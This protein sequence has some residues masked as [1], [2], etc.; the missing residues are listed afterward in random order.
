MF[1]YYNDSG[2]Y[3]F[4]ANEGGEAEDLTVNPFK[5][6]AQRRWMYA[7]DPAMAARW[8]AVTPKDEDLPEYVE[9][10]EAAKKKRRK[11]G[12][13]PVGNASKLRSKKVRQAKLKQSS[14]SNPARMDPAGLSPL[15]NA[16]NLWLSR[17]YDAFKTEVVK[18][19][20][21]GAALST[22][23][24][25]VFCP[26]GKGGGVDPGCSPEG[27]VRGPDGNPLTVYRGVARG[28]TEELGESQQGMYGKGY[29]FTQD[30][31]VA[32][33]YAA[34]IGAPEQQKKVPVEQIKEY[35]L[36][37]LKESQ[38]V[39]GGYATPGDNYRNVLDWVGSMKE[40][41]RLNDIAL[42]MVK[43]EAPTFDLSP[44]LHPS[45]QKR[46]IK[47]VHLTSHKML[48]LA[49]EV[50]KGDVSDQFEKS[51]TKATRASKQLS[52]Q[53]K[54]EIVKAVK[55]NSVYGGAYRKN[56]YAKVA[57]VTGVDRANDL[58]RS[59]G[60]DAIKVWG[61][62]GG[63]AHM[64]YVVFH[65]S[66]VK[67]VGSEDA[68]PKK[69]LTNRLYGEDLGNGVEYLDVAV[70]V[71]NFN[72]H[73]D[74]QGRFSSSSAT[75][76]PGRSSGEGASSS[77][78]DALKSLGVK[79]GHLHHMVEAYAS[80]KIAN[81]VGKLPKAAQSVVKTGWAG[82]FA[83]Y[84]AAQHMT[85]RIA[86]ER[87]LSD[88]EARRLRGTLSSFDMG[89][90]TAF[91]TA[92]IAGV[93]AAHLPTVVTGLIPVASASYLAYSTARH[94]IA[95]L[96]AACGVVKDVVTSRAAKAIGRAV[97][98]GYRA[99][100]KGVDLLAGNVSTAEANATLV[101]WHLRNHGYSD[102]YIALLS[103]AMSVT[104]NVRAALDLADHAW[105]VHSGDT[106]KP[107]NEG[108]EEWLLHTLPDELG[109]GVHNFN[110]HHDERGRF[111]SA[112]EGGEAEKGQP[113]IRKVS[114][115][116][117]R[118]AD[119]T[120]EERDRWGY[121]GPM[122]LAP[123][124]ESG[125]LFER[126]GRQWR[127]AGKCNLDSGRVTL[128][129]KGIHSKE[130]AITITN[131]EMMHGTFEKVCQ[132]YNVQKDKIR[133][134]EDKRIDEW[135][136][137]HPGAT[138][139]ERARVIDDR[140]A[141]T[142][143]SGEIKEEY[144]KQY[145]VYARMWRFRDSIPYDDFA[146][147]DGVTDYSKAYWKDYAAG[148]CTFHIAV[149]ET[150][151]EIAGHHAVTGVIIG[152]KLFRDYYKTVRDEYRVHTE[153][154]SRRR[155][156]HGED[157][158][159][160][161]QAPLFVDHDLYLDA[162]FKPTTPGKASWLRWWKA[163]GT[164]GWAVP[165]DQVHNVLNFNPYHD[166]KGRFSSS[167]E[168]GGGVGTT[169]S[170]AR[171]PQTETPAFKRWFGDSKVVD[172]NGK[173]R[174]CFHGSGTHFE[175]FKTGDNPDPYA[176]LDEMLGSHFAEDPTLSD[177]FLKERGE[178]GEDRYKTGAVLY[179]VYLSIQKPRVAPQRIMPSGELEHDAYAINRDILDTVMPHEKELFVK[180]IAKSR[181]VTPE[182]GREIF[183]R[184][185]RGESIGKDE[186]N[187]VVGHDMTSSY[188]IPGQPGVA[189]YLSNY[190][191]S[192]LGMS[193]EDKQYVVSEYKRRLGEMGYDGIVY[194]DT[195]PMEKGE[196]SQK[197]WIAFNPGQIKSATGNRGTF[198]PGDPN[199]H[200]VWSEEAHEAA[201]EARRAHM[202]GPAE[203]PSSA[204]NPSSTS[205]PGNVSGQDR[206]KGVTSRWASTLSVFG[207]VLYHAA[208]AIAEAV[209]DTAEDMGK[210]TFA[211]HAGLLR[212]HFGIGSNVS[213]VL[214]SHA[215]AFG[216]RKARDYIQ[217]RRAGK[218]VPATNAQGA[219]LGGMIPTDHPDFEQGVK[220]L[221]SL[222][223]TICGSLGIPAPTEQEVAKHMA[224]PRPETVDAGS[225]SVPQGRADVLGK[226]AMLTPF[227]PAA[228]ATGNP[229]PAVK[230]TGNYDFVQAVTAIAREA[231]DRKDSP[232]YGQLFWKP[233]M[234]E[235][236]YVTADGDE[237]EFARWVE[238]ELAKHVGN[239]VRVEAEG[240]PPRDGSWEILYPKRK[241]WGKP[242]DNE[243]QHFVHNGST[244]W[245][246]V[247]NGLK[248]LNA[249]DVRQINHFSCGDGAAMTVAW[250]FGVGPGADLWQRYRDRWQDKGVQD[251]VRK[252][253]KVWQDNLGTTEEE[254]TR[255]Q[256]IVD[257]L[258]RLG[259]YVEDS[260]GLTVQDLAG[261]IA[262]GMPI[263]VCCQ[264]YGPAVPAKARFD[265]GHYMV[266]IGVDGGYI[267]LQDPSEDNVVAGGDKEALSKTGSIQQPGRIMVAED[268]WNRI[269]I[270]RD[271]DGNVYDH[272]GIAVGRSPITNQPQ[273]VWLPIEDIL[274]QDETATP[275][276][277]ITDPD[278]VPPVLVGS[279]GYLIDGRHRI[280]GLKLGGQTHCWAIVS[281]SYGL[282][283]SQEGLSGVG[284][285]ND[286]TVNA[287]S[288][289]A[290]AAS[291][292][293]RQATRVAHEATERAWR[294][295]APA[296]RA[297]RN[298]PLGS[299]RVSRA[300]V[301]A[302]R[303]LPRRGM[304]SNRQRAIALHGAAATHHDLA[305][306]QH[307]QGSQLALDE[308]D[309][310]LAQMHSDAAAAHNR[311]VTAHLRA[312]TALG[313]QGHHLGTENFNPY[314]GERG[315]FTSAMEAISGTGTRED[316]YRCKGNIELA[317][318]LLAAGHHIR[319]EQ[320]E[321]VSTLLKEMHDMV[322]HYVK[323][324]EAPPQFDLCRVSIKGTNLFC[325]QHKGIPRV[326][327]PQMTGIPAPGTPAADESKYPRN[328][329]GK[330]S[331]A[332]DF[333]DHLQ[334]QGIKVT[335]EDIPA[336]HLRA[337]QREIS[338]RQV[339]LL[340]DEAKRGVRD[341]RKKPIW[342]SKEGYVIDGHHHWAAIVGYGYGKDKDLKVPVYR[343]DAEIG[344][345]LD[346]A[347][348]FAAH[349]G[350]R[351]EAVAN[352]NPYHDEMGR[353]SSG[354]VTHRFVTKGGGVYYHHDDGTTTRY[355]KGV[356]DAVRVVMERLEGLKGKKL[357]AEWRRRN[358][359]IQ[360][361]SS[362][363]F[364]IPAAEMKRLE[365]LGPG[366]RVSVKKGRL[367]VGSQP[368]RTLDSPKKGATPY[369]MWDEG[370]GP[371]G[372]SG[373]HRG[374]PITRVQRVK[375]PSSPAGNFNPHHGEHGRFA[376]AD[377]ALSHVKSMIA[378]SPHS[379][380]VGQV[381]DRMS[382]TAHERLGKH[383][384]SVRWHPTQGHLTA[385]L[386]QEDPK[387]KAYIEDSRTPDG[388]I[389]RIIK[390]AYDPRTGQLDLDG[391]GMH[392]GKSVQAHDYAAHELGHAVDGPQHELSNHPDFKQAWETEGKAGMVGDRG[393]V[394]PAEY[395]AE[396]WRLLHSEDFKGAR[397]RNVEANMPKT[398][399]FIRA[400]GL[401]PVTANRHLVAHSSQDFVPLQEEIPWGEGDEGKPLQDD[402]FGESFT[403][404][405]GLHIDVGPAE[406]GVSTSTA[407]DRATRG[408]T[409][410]H[411]AL[412]SPSSA[413]SSNAD[414]DRVSRFNAWLSRL[415]QQYL[416]G[417]KQRKAWYDFILNGYVKGSGR[418]YDDS[419]R[420]EQSYASTQDA[421]E[422]SNGTLGQ[423]TGNAGFYSAREMGKR[424]QFL[425]D[426]LSKQ[427]VKDRIQT[428]CDRAFDEFEGGTAD[429]VRRMKRSF[430]DALQ[431]NRSPEWLARR[432]ASDAGMGLN[433]ARTTARTELT[434]AHASAQ[435]Q[436]YR[437]LG[438]RE[439]GL[440]A[441]WKTAANPC[442]KCEPL[443]GV[444][445]DVDQ[446][447]G[448]IPRH[449]G[450]L[451][452]WQ[453]AS[454]NERRKD[455]IATPGAI[456][457]AFEESTDE[458]D[459]D[460]PGQEMI[461]NEAA[462]IDP[463][464]PDVPLDVALNAFDGFDG[465]DEVLGRNAWCPTGKGGGKDDSCSPSRGGGGGPERSGR[466]LGSLKRRAEQRRMARRVA[467]RMA[468][469]A[470]EEAAGV[471]KV[472]KPEEDRANEI[473]QEVAKM[474][475][476][477]W[478][479]D[480]EEMDVD[481]VKDMPGHV[482][483][484]K[485]LLFTT[486]QGSK[487]VPTIH[488]DALYRKAMWSKQTGDQYHLVVV[489]DRDTWEGGK[490][491]QYY[492][493]HRM[494][495]QRGCKDSTIS[496]MIPVRNAAH[497]RRLM[498]M[499]ESELPAT[500]VRPLPSSDEDLEDL[501]VKAVKAKESRVAK[502]RTYRQEMR[503][504]G[505]DVNVSLLG[506]VPK[507][508]KGKKRRR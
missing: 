501:R 410:D 219:F 209:L 23:I 103:A 304:D 432:L 346:R 127:E 393:K 245:H 91:K 272:Y 57:A 41:G 134:E 239:R 160:Q 243:Y 2:P 220:L 421:I 223:Q 177:S 343:L 55:L 263:I 229:S 327:M 274:G 405:D 73:H 181:G 153:Q 452:S 290:R 313:G 210:I 418:A 298:A 259:L 281:D 144:R 113:E 351:R 94:P 339:S 207:K 42:E 367:H 321:Q 106:S 105:T 148:K 238:G 254:S 389:H 154:Q 192:L 424:A 123:E 65:P 292:A 166:D 86:R 297:G 396:V 119:V 218:T 16:F 341:L 79:A 337:S 317:A 294:A 448:L 140:L 221:S 271:I 322:Q 99:A 269:W 377:E 467:K 289:A 69:F 264:D 40:G 25:N 326:K 171:V 378:G 169:P 228:A 162:D 11:K 244:V 450:C 459:D 359:E 412:G 420:A 379:E 288:D 451:C 487:A 363:T 15:C 260:H 135:N 224:H 503:A 319:L 354:D 83:V 390:G 445:L 78:V 426:H 429:T 483:E 258:R 206:L 331:I 498:R 89:T 329:K 308:G 496:Q 194:T 291:L 6:A 270:D 26:T 60:Y 384:S 306:Q 398:M 495:Y 156:Q 104:P 197:A 232:D 299:Y 213:L 433:R 214:A 470:A 33:V 256:A 155:K 401:M 458:G 36:K 39:K 303:E 328:K 408:V 324:D 174:V 109:D 478:L 59:M 372:Q 296:M 72:P 314:H 473:E 365:K 17:Q 447:E 251:Q 455:Q 499:D 138:L 472:A 143:P 247:G 226:A 22:I 44:V 323:G 47:H 236:W 315:R 204:A 188:R 423:P 282:A 145:P 184:L 355:S 348:E 217:A 449:P 7:N 461:G 64:M 338:G 279:D 45:I 85:E 285:P 387:I 307:I 362:R 161:A 383:L 182:Q 49:E 179:P 425:K 183:D 395:F 215:L 1:P 196:K 277:A 132:L 268:D 61:R 112:G 240:F 205:P 300:A 63:R 417:P 388:K 46:E 172:E 165:A 234:G 178:W 43:R 477:H 444:V 107:D 125:K 54:R 334:S 19:A 422:A 62:T 439:V 493:G 102:W 504:I 201:L 440:R 332:R 180:W 151:A 435:L 276:S 20:G 431:G 248:I 353:F 368:V 12:K 454:A 149:H 202:K 233:D 30:K 82:L 242:T 309:A 10:S 187:K 488:P 287:W 370:A 414:S 283:P 489:D 399:G 347:N 170:A 382:S 457:D 375:P 157:V 480:D 305:E 249:P 443:D 158:T 266:V 100:V 284:E 150:L 293:A 98:G 404:P 136:R 505:F 9:G 301:L 336:S 330:V 325:E 96:R 80:D 175:E 203:Q 366:A 340:V 159:N 124:T 246:P 139:G 133:E 168:G 485:S 482:V 195:A 167:D 231:K 198:D 76:S 416:T 373:Y 56:I 402:V 101:D 18:T 311:A 13:R 75:S 312:V 302:S 128:F 90:F 29:Y 407:G 35:I 211:K 491:K 265:Y 152:S 413:L 67:Q 31:N 411:G 14:R 295:Q 114:A 216:I 212:H 34:H 502:D 261:Y 117:A 419:T 486:Q 434:R 173:P 200:N 320:P 115:W 164:N 37:N 380:T 110:P 342:I 475:R 92:T 273:K 506:Q 456:R 374:H 5:S 8:E 437:D 84:R 349:M 108:D 350:L 193:R 252:V 464:D 147:D 185:S 468:K 51:V 465:R 364:Y 253:F 462:G 116:Y 189:S 262:R 333:I 68:D 507:P 463:F 403:A 48:D 74:E 38:C 28:G 361:R 391:P 137:A 428:L 97:A 163:D 381:L 77:I 50:S 335:R 250:L 141:M 95:T 446:A 24:G 386:M 227:Q 385:R 32:N 53:E 460:W 427:D 409:E 438:H 235:L 484:V 376:S 58:F 27:T 3:D 356:P 131:H 476:G 430:H 344:E 121:K 66:Q 453:L 199:I 316:P 492:S 275:R 87:G 490:H 497:L 406:E 286:P 191:S 469:M 357:E 442:S 111:S 508:K 415:V 318:R 371:R 70:G 352:A 436:A 230:P 241:P 118:L 222:M 93:A 500:A 186:Y 122:E 310:Y 360:P 146:K 88:E 129:S 71:D 397:Q 278:S 394:S 267:F 81:A 142:H 52:P 257:Y 176:N 345:C 466:R 471:K 494:Y 358:P 120:A 481:Q 400:A 474:V 237:E 208:P 441:E 21:D 130:Q 479:D 255:P 190:D 4:T 369:E 126:G 225:Q 280:E 392:L